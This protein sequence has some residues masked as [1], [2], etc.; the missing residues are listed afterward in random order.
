MKNNYEVT[1]NVRK[2]LGDE[3]FAKTYRIALWDDLV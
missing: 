2:E 1:V 3:V